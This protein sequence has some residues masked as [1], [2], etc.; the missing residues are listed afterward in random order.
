[1][2]KGVIRGVCVCD[3]ISD[4]LQSS[5]HLLS[6]EVTTYRRLFSL[7]YRAFFYLF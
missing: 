3:F 4:G 5:L 7:K 1:M 2:I 6:L